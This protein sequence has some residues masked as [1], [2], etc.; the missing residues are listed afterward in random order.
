MGRTY[1]RKPGSR[2]DWKWPGKKDQ[3]SYAYEDVVKTIESEN[4]VSY[5][6]REVFTIKATALEARGK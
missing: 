6:N 1:K 2:L 4:V 5:N 3:C